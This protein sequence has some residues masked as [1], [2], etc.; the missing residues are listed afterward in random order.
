M[1]YIK[2]ILTCLLVVV[3][4]LS[5]SMADEEDAST[6]VL[7]SRESGILAG[8]SLI[9]LTFEETYSLVIPA[10]L[11]ISYGAESTDMELNVSYM[12]LG[13]NRVLKVSAE[14][15][16]G[17]LRATGVTQTLP[18]QLQLNGAPFSNV[19]FKNAGSKTLKILIDKADWYAAPAGNYSDIV[20]FNVSIVNGQ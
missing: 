17:A 15:S 4:L 9:I 7:L 5:V 8:E 6:D 19:T 12:L 11:P 16:A 13:T 1:K 14:K 3:L 2:R 20:T 10:S 18:Y